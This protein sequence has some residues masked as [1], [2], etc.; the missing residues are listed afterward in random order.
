MLIGMSMLIRVFIVIRGSTVTRGSMLNRVCMLIRTSMLIGVSMLIRV[1]MLMRVFMLIRFSMLIRVTMLIRV[2]L[3]SRILQLVEIDFL[4][5]AAEFGHISGARYVATTMFQLGLVQN[6]VSTV[7]FYVAGSVRC[8][9]S[10]PIVRLTNSIL[11]TAVLET[12]R[13]AD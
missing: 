9:S 4:G 5:P 12:F 1:T 10:E 11:K 6:R 13:F 8:S 2:R 7:A 3:R